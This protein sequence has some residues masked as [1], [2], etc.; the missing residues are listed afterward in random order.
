MKFHCERCSTKYSI[1]DDRVRGKILKIRCKNCSDVITVRD[2]EYLASKAKAGKS[3]QKNSSQAQAGSS[4]QH[5]KSAA[6]VE[7]KSEP[8]DLASAPQNDAPESLEAEWYV[9]EDGEQEGPF[10]LPEARVWVGSKSTDAELY[11]WSE[12]FDD[13]LPV[14]KVSHFRGLRAA[15][16]EPEV[17]A[18]SADPKPQF[19]ATMAALSSEDAATLQDDSA[20]ED[21]IASLPVIESTPKPTKVEVPEEELAPAPQRPLLP[22]SASVVA[23]PSELAM[24]AS[25]RAQSATPLPALP[26]F[27]S[28]PISSSI[29]QSAP[30]QVAVAESAAVQSAAVQSATVAESAAVQSPA[31]VSAPELPAALTPE[32]DADDLDFDIGEASRIVNVSALLMQGTGSAPAVTPSGRPLPGTSSLPGVAAQPAGVGSP[33]N[34]LGIGRGTGSEATLGL[35]LESGSSPSFPQTE[36][37]PSVVPP[38]V[39]PEMAPAV[40]PKR[41]KRS[42]LLIPLIFAGATIVAVGGFLLYTLMNEAETSKRLTR[43][44]VAGS[45]NLGYSQTGTTIIIQKP[46]TPLVVDTTEPNDQRPNSKSPKSGSTG[47]RNNGTVGKNP[48]GKVNPDKV[49]RKDTPINVGE[50]DLTGG[51]PKGPTGP[52]DGEDLMRVYR[53]N[54]YSLTMCYKSSLKRD[55]L[56][57][58]PKTMVDVRV[59]LTGKVSSVRVGALSGTD[60]GQCIASRIR[61]W[62]FRQTTE[63]FSGRFQVIFNH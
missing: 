32:P 59:G 2:P 21:F 11:C 12:G 41:R 18:T 43:G 42:G 4:S 51:P 8:A 28:P 33:P 49:I 45:D 23:S 57:K 25:V 60:L 54:Q 44:S 10:E 37:T 35:G 46:D 26:S 30:V 29:S 38:S 7:P 62:K 3:S 9:S 13:W 48:V 53:K 17:T 63:V 40:S 15:V 50:V 14:E 56:L 61:R 1:S 39:F 58:V 27:V 6:R 34:S 47:K 16:P 55:S 24:S 19:A 22:V 5:S 52:L 36:L 20:S 31:P